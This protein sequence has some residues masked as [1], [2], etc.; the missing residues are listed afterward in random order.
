METMAKGRKSIRYPHDAGVATV[1]WIALVV[2]LA[3][4]TEAAT[5][6]QF[7]GYRVG[8]LAIAAIPQRTLGYG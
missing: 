7:N 8:F 5:I 4:L 1:R 6:H 3:R 2:L